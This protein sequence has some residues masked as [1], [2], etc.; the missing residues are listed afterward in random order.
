MNALGLTKAQISDILARS[1]NHPEGV[2]IM[3]S[4]VRSSLKLVVTAQKK[5]Y[6]AASSLIAASLLAVL[7]WGS[8]MPDAA[9]R[10]IVCMV[11]TELLVDASRDDNDDDG[12]CRSAAARCVPRLL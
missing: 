9:Q 3:T 10:D 2:L 7:F 1:L 11:L 4:E 8:L 5:K 12:I 6:V